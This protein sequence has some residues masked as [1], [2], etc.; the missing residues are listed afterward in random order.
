MKTIFLNVGY[1]K[2]IDA[3]VKDATN[4]VKST[5]MWT[6]IRNSSFLFA[7]VVVYIL[8]IS[9]FISRLNQEIW[10]AKGLLDVIPTKFLLAN[11]ELRGQFLSEY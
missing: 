8:I 1:E 3:F 4:Y 5:E 6:S 9:G 11:S 2:L 10:R 7:L